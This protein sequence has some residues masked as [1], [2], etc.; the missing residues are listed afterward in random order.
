MTS[1]DELSG[2]RADQLLERCDDLVGRL[3]A[4]LLPPLPPSRPTLTIV[5]DETE[6][7]DDDG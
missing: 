7:A 4:L 6:E 2:R 1:V 3:E 5:D